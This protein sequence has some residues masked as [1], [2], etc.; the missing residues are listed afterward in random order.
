MSAVAEQ[1][2]T[3]NR[4]ASVSVK[5]VLDEEP[6][7][8]YLGQYV[9][10]D[11]GEYII[12][13]KR[14]VLLGPYKSVEIY[15]DY[16]EDID[17]LLDSDEYTVNQ[18]ANGFIEIHY[19]PV[20]RSGLSRSGRGEY[21]WFESGNYSTPADEDEL[22]YFVQDYERVEDYN[23]AYWYMT[24]CVAKAVVMHT[25]AGGREVEEE[26]NTS[27]WGIESDSDKDYFRQTAGEMLSELRHELEQAGIDM[28]GWDELAAQAIEE[29]QTP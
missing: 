6:D 25:V 24:G 22:D 2:V 18:Y 13:R 12:D 27:V 29:M 19:R 16:E 15:T 21:E 4:I 7:L 20:L 26:F 9:G 11:N 8:S 10:K 1:L 3:S 28:S 5:F 23:K 17:A 14:G